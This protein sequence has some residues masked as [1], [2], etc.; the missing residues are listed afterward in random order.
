MLAVSSLPA[1]ACIAS[2]DTHYIGSLE[3][4][5][6]AQ[7]QGECCLT[8]CSEQLAL[9]GM[10]CDAGS[11][12][13]PDAKTQGSWEAVQD[14]LKQVCCEELSQECQGEKEGRP[15]EWKKRV[16]VLTNVTY[17]EEWGTAVLRSA[18]IQPRYT[19]IGCMNENKKFETAAQCSAAKKACCFECETHDCVDKPSPSYSTCKDNNPSAFMKKFGFQTCPRVGIMSIGLRPKWCVRV[20]AHS[21]V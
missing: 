11:F 15:G 16:A 14:R 5:P 6:A 3:R 18:N 17:L 2:T 1:H 12:A 10:S 19:L 4:F 7:L 9:K 13:R 20:G 8:T 21:S